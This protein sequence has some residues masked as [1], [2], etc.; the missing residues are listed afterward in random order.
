MALYLHG[1]GLSG[2]VAELAGSGTLLSAD[3]LGFMA[4]YFVNYMGLPWSHL[5]GL[6]IPAA[7]MAIGLSVLIVVLCVR[8]GLID[9]PGGLRERVA[10]GLLAFTFGTAVLAALGRARLGDPNALPEPPVKYAIFLSV[11]HAALAVA[12]LPWL[13]RWWDEP[14]KRA[15]V[16]LA[17]LMLGGLL[18]VQQIGLGEAAVAKAAWVNGYIAEFMA[19]QRDQGE[20]PLI[21]HMNDG[22]ADRALQFMR[23]ARIYDFRS[24]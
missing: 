16:Q 19:G 15:A 9:P 10:I 4:A 6:H 17:G 3:K 2:H 7:A 12:V 24:S 8:R 1:N 22:I 18:I 23:A 14:K 20:M 21:L 11:A 13:R 5:P